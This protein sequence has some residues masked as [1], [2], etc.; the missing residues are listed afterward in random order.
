MNWHQE[1]IKN[2]DQFLQDL[3]ELLRIKSVKDPS[4]A[5]KEAPMGAAVGEALDYM[6]KLA[7]KDGFRTKNID[8]YAG[9][10]EMGPEEAENYIAVLCH[11]DVVPASSGWS[12]DPFE[13]EIRDG[14]LFAR[15]AMDDKGPTMAAYYACK[16]VNRLGLPLDHRIRIIFGTDEESGMSC[17][18]RYMEVEEPPIAG[19]APDA[20]FPIIHAEKGQVNI[21]F[22]LERTSGQDGSALKLHSFQAGERANVVPDSASARL[23]VERA[24]AVKDRF[25]EFCRSTESEGKASVEDNVLILT[26]NGSSAHAMEPDKG[27][28]AGTRLAAFLK[29]EALDPDGLAYVSFAALLDDDHFGSRLGIEFSDSIT[30]PLTVNPGILSFNEEEAFIHLNLRMPVKASYDLTYQRLNQTASEFGFRQSELRE[31]LPHH[32]EE[33]HP[34]IKTLQRVYS[35]ESGSEPVLLS[36]GGNTYARTIPGGVAFGALFPGTPDTAHQKDECI[37]VEELIKAS[38]IYARAIFEL[39]RTSF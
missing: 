25:A 17:M 16:L 26:L 30:G 34:L 5:S 28:N 13:P 23:T 20:D 12:S 36:T 8:G 11:V 22:S 18:Q 6:L 39:G 38:S 14:V 37:P 24:K 9:Y 3:K 10:A 32:V 7:E 27:T 1:T 21:R 4:T 19:F 35:D 2:R 31:R 15:G 29:K 33:G